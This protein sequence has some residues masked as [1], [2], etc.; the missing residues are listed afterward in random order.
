MKKLIATLLVG[1][2]ALSMSAVVAQ[3]DDETIV[4]Y[5]NNGSEGRDEWLVNR[6]AEAGFTVEVVSL[7]ASEV[8]ERMI[9]EKNNPLCDVT[10]GLNN[11]EYEKLKANDLLQTWEP[12]WVDGVDSSLVDAD[13]YFYPVTTTPLLL[14]GNAEYDNMPSDWTDLVNE[15]YAGLYQL[16]KLSGGTA[17]TVYASII[18]RYADPDGELGISEEGWEVAAAFIGNAHNIAEGEDSIGEVIDGTY[19]L[20]EHWASGV[21]TE[22]K[23]RGYDFQIMTPEVGEPFVVESLAI[24]KDT[25]KYDLCVEF[26]NWLGSAEIQLEWSDNFGTIPCQEEA[27]ANVSDELKELMDVL[28]PQELDWAFIAENIDAWVEKAELEFVQ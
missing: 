21:I 11:I 14:I 1:T 7:G 4:V 12:D 9:A 28:T 17:R 25:D 23:E 16:H 19:P 5:T 27:L 26:L 8:T 6:A 10:F 24:A 15:E 20:D 2:M 13:G 3:A 22:E 18:S